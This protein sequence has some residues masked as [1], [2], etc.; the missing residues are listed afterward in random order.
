MARHRKFERTGGGSPGGAD[1]VSLGQATSDGD[2]DSGCGAPLQRFC[3]GSA[4]TAEDPSL[5][6]PL[7]F[8]PAGARP[9]VS[10]LLDLGGRRS[11]RRAGRYRWQWDIGSDLFS[12]IIMTKV[13]RLR[14]GLVWRSCAPLPLN[15]GMCHC[16]AAPH[17]RVSA[18]RWQCY[19]GMIIANR[20]KPSRSSRSLGEKTFCGSRDQ[21]M[22]SSGWF[23]SHL[24]TRCFFAAKKS[25]VT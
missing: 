13:R 10:K 25:I 24:A 3:R 16:R 19:L 4:A 9:P 12:L 8:D 21:A 11:A 1:V 7:S 14:T 20:F 15:F 23:Y 18:S 22:D 5:T 2:L 6:V 17:S